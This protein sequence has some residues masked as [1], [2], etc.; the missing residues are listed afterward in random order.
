MSVCT[1][2]T[3]TTFAVAILRFLLHSCEKRAANE[4]EDQPRMDPPSPSLRR[5]TFPRPM[6]LVDSNLLLVL[7]L[8]LD[9]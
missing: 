8:V 7:V 4:H 9:L 1:I 5:D 3:L 6:L 2:P